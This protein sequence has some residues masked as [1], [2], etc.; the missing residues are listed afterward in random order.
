MMVPLTQDL[1]PFFSWEDW[2]E[3]N[4]IAGAQIWRSMEKMGRPDLVHNGLSTW[5]IDGKLGH[6]LKM[7]KQRGDWT[8]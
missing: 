2:R 1:Q 5:L 6:G 8:A 4:K 7:D 3:V